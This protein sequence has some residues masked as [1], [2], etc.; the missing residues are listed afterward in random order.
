M[1]FA[2]GGVGRDRYGGAFLALGEHLEQQFGA[3]PVQ[4]E[5]TQLI[6]AQKVDAAVA[7][8]GAGQGLVVG[9]LDELV[10]QGGSGTGDA[11]ACRTVRRCTSY[12]RASARTGI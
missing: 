10:D 11:I 4:L 9:G 6:Q 8:D 3:A 12:F 7:G 2:E 1:R 5:V